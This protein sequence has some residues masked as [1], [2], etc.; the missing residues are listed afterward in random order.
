MV[1]AQ[2]QYDDRSPSQEDIQETLAQ[3]VE[4]SQL[5]CTGESGTSY[6]LSH[7]M[8]EAVAKEESNAARLVSAASA[9][10]WLP[11]I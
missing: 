2:D 8:S 11:A 7:A 3:M 4:E 9:I 5:T 6:T 1:W 10:A